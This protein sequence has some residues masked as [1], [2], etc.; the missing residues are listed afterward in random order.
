[1]GVGRWPLRRLLA[2]EAWYWFEGVL[3]VVPGRIGRVVRA[4]AYR[5]LLPRARAIGELTHIRSPRGLRAGTGVEIGRLSQLTCTGGLTIGDDVLIG[6]RVTIVTNNHA[7]EDPRVRI[8]HQGS[9]DGP[10]V[11]GDDVWIGAGATVL[12]GVTIGSG[13]VVAAGAVVTRSVPDRAVVAGVPA[14]VLRS[15]QA[16]AS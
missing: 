9:V 5:R 12:A 1:M 3:G 8:K 2:E 10:V 13:A 4:A 7:V 6:P 15:R 16:E 14:K 11:I